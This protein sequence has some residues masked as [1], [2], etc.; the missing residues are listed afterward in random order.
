MYD[1]LTGLYDRQQFYAAL[2]EMIGNAVEFSA[3]MGLLLIDI[4]RF[5]KINRN[6]GHPAG[7][8]VLQTVANVLKQ[9]IREGDYIGRIGDDQFAVL[10]SRITNS[11]HAQLAA[12]KIQRLLDIPVIHKGVEIRCE[13][14]MGISLCPDNATEAGSLLQTAEQALDEAKYLEEAIGVSKRSP[15]EGISEDWDIEVSL[16]E[17]IA[18]SEME[19]YFQPKISL[20]TGWPVGAEALVR[21][22]SP[23]RGLITPNIFLPVA[24]AI[25]FLKPLT[26]WMLN[27]ALR[28]SSEWTTKWGKLSVSVNIPPRILEQSDFVDLVISAEKLWERENVDLCLEILEESLVADVEVVFKKLTELRELG[29][30]IAIDDFGT[31]YSSLSY[32]RDLPTDELKIDQSFIRG[33]RS[34]KANIHIVNLI[35]ELAHRFGLKVIAEGVE[36]AKMIAYLK[37]RRCHQVQ[38]Y[39]FSKPMPAREFANWLEN[40][41]PEPSLTK[42]DDRPE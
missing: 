37:S 41:Q 32:F 19:V 2:T 29:V 27:S 11:G 33:M 3:P 8:A 39:Y 34:D 9:V 12:I 31:G 36:D 17:S 26:V 1:K 15:E 10:L 14:T 42:T 7:D 38:G 18:R 5:R 22:E 16:G 35:I 4:R 13:A 25:G 30:K 21:W 40:Y 28:L 24:E 6:Y 23:M 20:A